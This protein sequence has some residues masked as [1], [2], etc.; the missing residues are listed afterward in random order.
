MFSLTSETPE[1]ALVVH[2]CLNGGGRNVCADGWG[3]D[4]VGILVVAQR[5]DTQT[6]HK[7]DAQLYKSIFFY[8]DGPNGMEYR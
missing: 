4:G 6:T 5:K 7:I 3:V 1:T 2:V 8:S